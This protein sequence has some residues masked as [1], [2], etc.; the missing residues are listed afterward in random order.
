MDEVTSP[1]PKTLKRPGTRHFEMMSVISAC[2]SIRHVN[3][4][5]VTDG[6]GFSRSGKPVWPFLFFL[7]LGPH[8]QPM[9]VPRLGV[10]SK[11]QLPAYTSA[12]SNAGSLTC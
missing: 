5:R 9:E 11:V 6:C 4:P 2:E 12:H 10:R 1:V 8:L 3:I 7:V